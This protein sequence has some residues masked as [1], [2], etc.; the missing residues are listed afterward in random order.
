MS[1]KSPEQVIYDRLSTC[2]DTAPLIGN[3][4]YPIVAPSS[5]AMPFAVY[6]RSGIRRNQTL[7]GVVG[8]PTVTLEIAVYGETYNGVRE[9]ADA[10]R[11]CLDGWGGS[12][13]GVEVKRASL[14]DESDGLAT[15]EGGEVPPMYS[16]TQYYEVLWQ[17]T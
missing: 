6:R 1:L 16:V 15:L 4:V 12:A 10:F 14:T 11:K 2:S 8:V 13:Y 5:T 3:R 17:E 9:V 7:S